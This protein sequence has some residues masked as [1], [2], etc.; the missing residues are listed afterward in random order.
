ML[1]PGHRRGRVAGVETMN[2]QRAAVGAEIGADR[3]GRHRDRARKYGDCFRCLRIERDRDK[4]R[5]QPVAAPE[6]LLNRVIWHSVKGYD[7]LYPDSPGL[8]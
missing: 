7:V 1:Y 3:A 4:L 5:S 6:E 8:R 2:E